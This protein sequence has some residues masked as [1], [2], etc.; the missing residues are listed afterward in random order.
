M[1]ARD[2]DP[3]RPIRVRLLSPLGLL[4]RHPVEARGARLIARDDLVVSAVEMKPSET[5]GIGLEHYSD[6]EF[7]ALEEIRF[8]ASISLAV[9]PADGM[10]Y[11]Y[12][13]NTAFDVERGLPDGVVLELAH[14]YV[15]RFMEEDRRRDVVLP[16][17][18]GGPPYEW[19]EKGVNAVLVAELVRDIS[20][21]DH[22][23]MR[24]L[25]ALL[26]SNMAWRHQEIAEAG[27][28]LLYVALDA[29][30]Q[31]VLRVL[32]E[33]GLQNP[34]ALDAGALID[35]VF[36][37]HLCTGSYFEDFYD[38]RITTMHPS[39]RFGI[40]PVAPLEA[41]DFLFLRYGLIE[42]YHWLITKRVHAPA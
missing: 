11:V 40:F 26:R 36:N 39:S 5:H 9:P 41:D 31:L 18:A 1:S 14:K 15:E 32:R 19:R 6:L 30:F 4:P 10:A 34:S 17:V 2:F 37:P 22:L 33:R 23:L 35:E 28:L 25:S 7:M 42:V 24:G 12:P 3:A 8:L 38:A 27:Q 21:T 29:S 13:L 16:P 20:L